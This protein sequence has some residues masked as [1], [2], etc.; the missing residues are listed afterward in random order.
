MHFSDGWFNDSYIRGC[1]VIVVYAP[2]GAPTAFANLMPEYTK[3]EVAI[4]LMRHYPGVE[5]GTMEYMF[6]KMLMWAREKGYETF[7]LGLSAIVAVGEKPDDP[8]V[9]QTLYKIATYVSRY[10]NFRGLH[11]FKDKFHPRWEP[12]YL[13]YPGPASLPLV[14]STLLRVHSGNDYLWKFLGKQPKHG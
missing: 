13:V 7:S 3:N 5:Q 10:F 2:D 1:P 12:R 9:E 4:D 11:D 6:A 14:F 8:R